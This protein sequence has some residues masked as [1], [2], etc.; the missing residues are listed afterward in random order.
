M[1]QA[2]QAS[3]IGFEFIT[4]LSADLARGEVELPAFPE[5]A[6]RIKD[7]LK[8]PDVSAATIA[9]IAASDPVL[10]ARFLQ[11]ANSA[12]VNACGTEIRN[13]NMAIARMGFKLAQNTAT[14]FAIA[15]SVKSGASANTH[16]QLE[17]LW[18][19]SIEVAAYAY[20]IA[21]KLAKNIKPDEA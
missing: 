20:V 8:D 13:L 11:V 3:N 9:R 18:S 4:S 15:H 14:S 1:S 2:S 19:H 21:G 5:V 6:L 10:S 7:A 16:P 17:P 12:L